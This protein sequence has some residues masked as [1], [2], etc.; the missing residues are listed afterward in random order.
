METLLEILQKPFVIGL[1]IGLILMFVVW[2][3]SLRRIHELKKAHAE[4]RRE[5]H[6]KVARLETHVRT[7]MELSADGS[8]AAKAE[9]E[10][11]KKQLENLR[12]TNNSL[13]T[14]PGRAELRQLHLYEKAL[15]VMNMRAPGFS[16][17]WSEATRDAEVELE[18][19]EQGLMKWIRKPFQLGKASKAEGVTEIEET[20]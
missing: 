3:R 6:A 18:K 1:I 17:A 4:E 20:Q 7:Q 5:L 11:L 14:K 10:E 13:S 2:F 15:S 12:V 16:V 8:V 9:V 19:E